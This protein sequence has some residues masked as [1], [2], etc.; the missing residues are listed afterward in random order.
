MYTR[1]GM[2]PNWFQINADNL[3][4]V[5]VLQ[6]VLGCCNKKQTHSGRT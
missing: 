5:T 1:L 4:D 6:L 2:F 3:I